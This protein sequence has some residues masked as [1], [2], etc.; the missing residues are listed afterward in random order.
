MGRRHAGRG[1]VLGVSL[2]ALLGAGCT[3]DTTTPPPATSTSATRAE[4]AQEREERVAYE[5]AEKSYREFRAELYRVLRSGGAKAP[6][7]V[8]KKT[9]AGPYLANFKDL[10][11]AYREVGI[12]SEGEEKIVYVREAG[13]S[14]RAVTFDVCEDSRDVKDY[15]KKGRYKGKGELRKIQLEVRLES[16]Q[17]KLWDGE[18][19][20]V[21]SCEG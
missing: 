1:F 6:T 10:V 9:A 15:D 7:A 20:K 19:Q 8:M 4:S 17:W 11:V 5:A 12:H 18:G 14:P 3:P 13:Y 16:N 2:L 21:T